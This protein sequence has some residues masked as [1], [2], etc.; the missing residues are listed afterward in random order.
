[1]ASFLGLKTVLS[2]KSSIHLIEN[3]TILS[4]NSAVNTSGN[5][6]HCPASTSSPNS[7]S[8]SRPSRVPA[9]ARTVSKQHLIFTRKVGIDRA[10]CYPCHPRNLFD[11][12]PVKTFL[13]KN[14]DRRIQNLSATCGNKHGL[15]GI[16]CVVHSCMLPLEYLAVMSA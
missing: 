11:R 4:K 15:N 6:S 1:M 14:G 13:R 16:R 3:Y 10:V 12:S 2:Q 7:C 9:M 8:K 5:A